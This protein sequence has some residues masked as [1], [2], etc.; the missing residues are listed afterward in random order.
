MLYIDINAKIPAAQMKALL[1]TL[2]KA[3][4]ACPS[5]C[6]MSDIYSNISDLG[7]TFKEDFE[8]NV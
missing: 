7:N 5:I 6:D 2:I 8:V 3:S 4:Y 1:G